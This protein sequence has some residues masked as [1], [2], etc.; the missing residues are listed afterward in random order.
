MT[1][2]VEPLQITINYGGLN[3]SIQCENVNLVKRLENYYRSYIGISAGQ[4]A[5]L[6]IRLVD[7]PVDENWIEPLITWTSTGVNV[8]A[9]SYSGWVNDITFES[10]LQLSRFYP[11][12]K[13]DHFLRVATALWVYKMGG[14][15]L[16]AAALEKNGSGY[17]FTGHSGR[18][19]TTVCRVSQPAK[20]LNDDLIIISEEA[21]G[22]KVGSTPFTNPSQVQP[23]PGNTKLQS[24]L[25]LHQ[26][27]KNALVRQDPVLALAD[28]ITHIPVIPKNIE[29]LKVVMD[30]CRK[31]IDQ[32]AVYN[33]YFLPDNSFWSLIESP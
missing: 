29:R 33:L 14:L 1:A 20:V 7:L 25:I 4:N 21:I 6:S 15:F 10:H 12:Q 9:E 32:V 8:D 28:L 30:R 13:I 5:L 3:L 16:H 11:L 17:I 26:A 2:L 23:N 24:I 19:K 22:W 31:L 27:K 18:G